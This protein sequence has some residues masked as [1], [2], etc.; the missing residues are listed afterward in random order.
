MRVVNANLGGELLDDMPDE[1]FRY[2]F[3]PSS[4]GAAHTPEKFPRVNCGSLR[5]VVQAGCAPNPGR[6]WFANVT[7]VSAQV[8]DRP[9]PFAL[10]QV[11]ESQLG[12]LMAT[13]TAGP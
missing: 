12:E 8:Y 1:L 9:M 10:L 3:A 2:S 4:S 11:A 6:E 13:E 7:S 5:P